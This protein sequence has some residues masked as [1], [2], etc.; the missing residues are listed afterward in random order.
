MFKKI[1]KL[2]NSNRNTASVCVEFAFVAPIFFLIVIGSIEFARV[3]MIQAAV[4]NACFEGAR[5]GIIP[6]STNA[7]CV[8]RTE[9]FLESAGVQDYTIE[10][11]PLVIDAVTPEIVVT[12]TVK[13]NA[14]NG[15][16]IS[17]F[18]KDRSMVKRIALPTQ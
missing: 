18:F 3:H 14:K 2:K 17:G 8:Q 16:G 11:Q 5:R 12:T 9:E 10:V 6:G 1:R 13:L 4:E 15:F 7:L